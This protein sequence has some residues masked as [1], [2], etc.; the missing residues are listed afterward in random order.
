MAMQKSWFV[1]NFASISVLLLTV[2]T[3]AAPAWGDQSTAAYKE[4]MRAYHAKLLTYQVQPGRLQEQRKQVCDSLKELTRKDQNVDSLWAKFDALERRARGTDKAYADE[5]NALIA[6]V[7][8]RV[9]Q[10]NKGQKDNYDNKA[11][12]NADKAGADRAQ[13]NTA[14]QAQI[15]SMIKDHSPR[16]GAYYNR[17]KRI[18][19]ELKRCYVQKRNCKKG[20]STIIFCSTRHWKEHKP[21]ATGI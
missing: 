12:E 1:Q 21:Q 5:C 9:E 16:Y 14:R 7:K 15:A 6:E 10:Y 18:W 20:I 11:K 19:E 2:Q 17:R 8:T 4:Q 3:I 13:A